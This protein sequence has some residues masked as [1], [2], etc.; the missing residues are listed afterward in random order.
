MRVAWWDY[1]GSLFLAPYLWFKGKGLQ[2]KTE[3]AINIAGYIGI[4]IVC[5]F[6]LV[7]ISTR[8]GHEL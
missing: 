1:F 5:L 4:G 6:V 8:V 3:K 7:L 2:E